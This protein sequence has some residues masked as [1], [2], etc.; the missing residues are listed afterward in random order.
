MATRHDSGSGLLVGGG[1]LAGL[2]LLYTR[3]VKPKF[4]IPLETKNYVTR[5]RVNPP[6]VRFKGNYVEFDLPIEN[7]NS[8]PL[9][10]KAIVG[11]IFV[12]SNDGKTVYKLGTVSRYGTFVIQPVAESKFTFQV[13]MKLLQEVAF[14]SDIFA[15]KIHGM[16]FTFSGNVNINGQLFPVKESVKIS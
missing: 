12:I 3:V 16:L 4:V 6:V 15:G 11:D 10:I 9:I 14:F 8:A 2:C 1:I 5:M 13:R 7:P